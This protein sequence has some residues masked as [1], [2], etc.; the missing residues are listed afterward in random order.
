MQKS[1]EQTQ[2]YL[3]LDHPRQSETQQ[4]STKKGLFRF[5]FSRTIKNIIDLRNINAELQVTNWNFSPNRIKMIMAEISV[6]KQNY[7]PLDLSGLTVLDVGAG[8]GETAKF[9][10]N[11][12]A[13]KIICIESNNEAYRQLARN[14]VAHPAISAIHKRFSISDLC[15]PHDF[16]KC[17]I[18]GYE[19][20]LLEVE[21][22]FP[23]A[24]EVHGLQLRDK[25]KRAGWR[26]VSHDNINE[27]GCTCYAY[28]LC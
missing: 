21:L 24:V 6:W 18:E 22:C 23:A 5:P 7:L 13:A 3:D 11:H 9:F 16:L 20:E 17:D 4:L 19:E 1:E 14:A 15:L 10:L 8:E 25:F 2:V 27:C 12:G 28:W 26:I